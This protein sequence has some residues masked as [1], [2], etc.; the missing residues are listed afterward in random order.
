MLFL[1]F[2][3]G[4]GGEKLAG[5]LNQMFR[6]QLYADPQICLLSYPAKKGVLKFQELYIT[7]A[8]TLIFEQIPINI[9][10]KI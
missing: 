6:V 9:I 10:L 5:K 3:R 1:H 2:L 4:I 7:Y 8:I